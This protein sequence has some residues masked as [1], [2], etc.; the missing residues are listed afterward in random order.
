MDTTCVKEQKQEHKREP[1]AKRRT[2]EVLPHLSGKLIILSDLTF[3][4]HFSW[5]PAMAEQEKG[6]GVLEGNSVLN[7]SKKS[8]TTKQP[9]CVV[10]NWQ[11][12]RHLRVSDFESASP[13]SSEATLTLPSL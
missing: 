11:S 2:V 10:N 3:L 6:G 8:P 1:V 12:A 9:V 4:Q 7:T 5:H 13:L